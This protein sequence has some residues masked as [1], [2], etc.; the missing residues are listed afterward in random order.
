MSR[1]YIANGPSYRDPTKK[2]TVPRKAKFFPF[3]MSK[4]QMTKLKKQ[5]EF[6][7]TTLQQQKERNRLEAILSEYVE[8][9]GH[10]STYSPNVYGKITL[11]FFDP[12]IL[13]ST[14][15]SRPRIPLPVYL[16]L[17]NNI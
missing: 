13:S 4:E 2:D 10:D 7:N 5:K 14:H 16:S 1:P 9:Y 15:I 12:F 8:K 11:L 17:H 3:R 6:E